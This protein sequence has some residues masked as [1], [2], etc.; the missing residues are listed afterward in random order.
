MVSHVC[1]RL[2]KVVECLDFSTQTK[3]LFCNRDVRKLVQYRVCIKY[4]KNCTNK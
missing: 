1:V 4:D 2:I 3:S